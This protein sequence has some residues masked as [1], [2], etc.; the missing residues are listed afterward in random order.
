[1]IFFFFN[2]EIGYASYEEF[3]RIPDSEVKST[4][5]LKS[6]EYSEVVERVKDAAAERMRVN[7][8]IAAQSC[9]NSLW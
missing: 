5:Y 3:G 4:D 9:K 7:A 6:Q 1:M 2:F 8:H